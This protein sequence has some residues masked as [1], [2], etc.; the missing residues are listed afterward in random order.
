MH[1]R[2]VAVLKSAFAIA[3]AT[4]AKTVFIYIDPLDDLCYPHPIPRALQL[5]L[6]TKKKK[7]DFS[8]AEMRSLAGRAKTMLVLPKLSLT[9]ASLLK[10]AMMLALARDDIVTNDVMVCV[11]GHRDQDCLDCIQRIDPMKE[12]EFIGGRIVN[13]ISESIDPA[14]FETILNLTIELAENGREGKPVGTVFVVGDS[15]RVMQ[16]SK[17]MIINPFK[18]YDEDERNILNPAIKETIREFS[19]LDGAFVIDANG[20]IITAGRYLVGAAV[21]ATQL[22]RGLGSRHIAAAGITALTKAVAFVISESSG[23]ARIF[24]DGQVLMDIEKSQPGR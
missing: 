5:V 9:R 3:R 18:G 22:P 12:R 17:Q 23:D 8:D 15:E 24:K 11:T 6:I 4:G 7:H 20:T 19:G 21:D 10:I 13:R 16:L 14:V 1:E 2:N